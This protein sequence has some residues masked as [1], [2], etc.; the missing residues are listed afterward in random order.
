MADYL[1]GVQNLTGPLN[2]SKEPI[3]LLSMLQQNEL[4]KSGTE[5]KG[6]TIPTDELDKEIKEKLLKAIFG[7]KAGNV[8][9]ASKRCTSG[10][11]GVAA[12]MKMTITPYFFILFSQSIAAILFE[13]NCGILNLPMEI[14]FLPISFLPPTPT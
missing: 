6:I 9:D 4:V 3:A 1:I 12:K 7:E 11:N 5:R 10:V 14:L 2:M 8:K 13:Y